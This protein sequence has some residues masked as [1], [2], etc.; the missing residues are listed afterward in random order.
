[1]SPIHINLLKDNRPPKQTTVY[2]PQPEYPT[3]EGIERVARE[4]PNNGIYVTA[5]KRIVEGHS[6]QTTPA[7]IMSQAK[8]L[9][10]GGAIASAA[11]YALGYVASGG[12]HPY[13]VDAMRQTLV[14]YTTSATIVTALGEATIAHSRRALFRGKT[15][16]PQN[17][18][19]LRQSLVNLMV[20]NNIKKAAH[21][22]RNTI[23]SGTAGALTWG[24]CAWLVNQATDMQLNYALCMSAGG[25]VGSGF[26]AAENIKGNK[27]R[28]R[29]LATPTAEDAAK[30][31]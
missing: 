27:R 15:V 26:A 9:A 3:K 24:A 21:P 2:I 30:T 16:T 10:F 29:A 17:T 11:G 18:V 23:Y 8:A 25:I 14:A 5:A 6:L 20:E 22:I 4:E 13:A 1:M 7:Y 12:D 19:D 28:I 31:T